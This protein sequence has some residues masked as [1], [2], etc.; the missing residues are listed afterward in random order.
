MGVLRLYHRV[1]WV[2]EASAYIGMIGL[3]AATL[4]LFHPSRRYVYLFIAL[5]VLSATAAFSIPPVHW[6]VVRLPIVKAMKNGRL[7]L[8]TDFA[9]SCL[10]C[11][12]RPDGTR[13]SERIARGSTFLPANELRGWSGDYSRGSSCSRSPGFR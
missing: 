2:P 1:A 7:M 6:I 12:R 9:I 5:A 10:S 3:M 4:S 8:V 13:Y 11:K